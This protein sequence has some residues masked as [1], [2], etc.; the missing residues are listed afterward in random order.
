MSIRNY[1][2]AQGEL[3]T[4]LG[5]YLE[6]HGVKTDHLFHCINP[7]HNDKTP[8]CSLH[9]N[10]QIFHCF[11]GCGISGNIFHAANF[12]EGKSLV[13]NEF[14][15]ENLKY[16]AAKYGIEIEGEPLSEEQL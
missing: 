2:E 15:E 10:G 9:P 1:H 8:S 5:E 13:G 4:K 6:E 11:G 12:L 14:V 7:E 3:F 16:L